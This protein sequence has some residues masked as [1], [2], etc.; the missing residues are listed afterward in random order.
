MHRAYYVK[1][2]E[3]TL[4]EHGEMLVRTNVVDRIGLSV[5]SPKGNLLSSDVY[6]L[7]TMVVK[8]R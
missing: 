2:V 7:A 5:D 1:T 6:Q 3:S 8:I 4:M